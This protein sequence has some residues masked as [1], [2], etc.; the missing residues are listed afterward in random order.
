MPTDDVLERNKQNV[1]A[2]YDLTFDQS[3]PRRAGSELSFT[4]WPDYQ[5]WSRGKRSRPLVAEGATDF[6][7]RVDEGQEGHWRPALGVP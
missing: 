6:G 4:N 2:F 5:R 1:L 3:R 7:C